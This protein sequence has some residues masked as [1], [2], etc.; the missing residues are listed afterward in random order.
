MH[1]EAAMII[2]V[3]PE[4]GGSI[5]S[6]SFSGQDER[7][8]TYYLG[9]YARSF[10]KTYFFSYRKE[11]K[12]LPARC[13]L[14]DNKWG[15]H[16]WLYGPLLPIL[17]K[18]HFRRCSLLRVMQATG[19][20]PALLA[21]ALFRV[22]VVATYGYRYDLHARLEGHWFRSL[23]FRLRERIALPRFD[24]VIITNSET[25]RHVSRYLPPERIWYIPN[26]VDTALFRPD[27]EGEKQSKV[28]TVIAVG[29]LR[30]QKNYPLLLEA[31]SRLGRGVKLKIIGDGT[32]LEGLR[33]H[34]R[35]LKVDVEFTGS[36]PHEKLPPYLNQADVF[37]MSSYA[38][39]HPKALLEAMSC[40]LP[41]V[42]VAIEGIK[43]VITDG[44][45]GLVCQAEPGDLARA[46]ARL[47]D[48]KA[49][50]QRLGEEARRSV[51]EC[52]ELTDLIDQ[53]IARH[54]DLIALQTRGTT[55][56]WIAALRGRIARINGVRDL[57]HKVREKI[58]NGVWS[59]FT[60]R[61]MKVR[62]LIR[63]RKQHVSQKRALRF[64]DTLHI[65]L[66]NRCNLN[67]AMCSHD[68]MKRIRKDMDFHLFRCLI[69]ECRNYPVDAISLYYF[70]EALLY[71]HLLEA[72]RYAHQTLDGV[73]TRIRTNAQLL[74]E[75]RT[76][77]LL[78]SGLTALEFSLEGYTREVYET[79]MKGASYEET[80]ERL[81]RYFR[82]K[83]EL[84][85]RQ[86]NAIV[87]V[88]MDETLPAMKQF[89]RAWSRFAPVSVTRLHSGFVTGE[90][91][92]PGK[93]AYQ[94]TIPCPEP[95]YHAMVLSNGEVT[96]CC[97]DVEGA[98][99]IGNITRHNLHTIWNSRRAEEIRRLHRECAFDTLPIC[100]Q[101]SN[102]ILRQG[103]IRR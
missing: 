18:R 89:V 40:G 15:L 39:G 2:G 21:K 29:G 69:D 100:R 57:I 72:I 37:V 13:E 56:S 70:G 80:L 96:F 75:R 71:P 50:S 7:L 90:S 4:Q 36:I 61:G 97:C 73:H 68:R 28:K 44:V 85:I 82:L 31:I 98:L 86:Q 48:D 32:L 27:P 67:C 101:C 83:K 92:L 63:K 41:C 87:T 65:E 43:D 66:T 16:R 93:T 5:T 79:L 84:G 6:Y 91:S 34:A 1:N 77:E 95:F 14:A 74:T 10:D 38:E 60:I 94:R 47:L 49:L 81:G 99:S 55:S 26:G 46:I 17:Y 103:V 11:S 35:Q 76:R 24:A 19:E 88:A 102:G 12:D 30:R 58:L 59:V 20:V 54:R 23:L 3:L 8:V 62:A 45:N 53:E 52:Y 42:G 9:S 33:T 64:P 78:A 25:Y 51:Q 22:P